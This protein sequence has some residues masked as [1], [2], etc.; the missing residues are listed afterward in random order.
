MRL[1]VSYGHSVR[2]WLN[3]VCAAM[4]VTGAFAVLAV[5]AAGPASVEV[6][7]GGP[8]TSADRMYDL[9][10]SA[11]GSASPGDTEGWATGP[12]ALPG[13]S[14]GITLTQYDTI[15]NLPGVQVA[16]PLTMVGYV[17]LTVQV[18]VEIPVVTASRAARPVTLTVRVSSDNG[19]SNVTWDDVTMAYPGPAVGRERSTMS[20]RLGWTFLLPLVAVD[21]VAEARLVGLDAAVTGGSYLPSGA[22]AASGPVPMLMAGSV[23]D[24][25]VADVSVDT[26]SG[27][28]IPAL[29]A[30]PAATA[31]QGLIG[32]AGESAAT[33]RTYW[34]ASPVTYQ[35][36]P[37][38]GAMPRPVATDLAAVWGGPYQWAGAPADAGVLDVTFR[39]LTAH[40]AG[41]GAALRAVGVFDPAKIAGASASPSPY[42]PT[43]LTG[44]DARSRQLLGGRPLTPD[45]APGGYN[46]PAA[47]LVIPLADI[48][49][50]TG[51]DPA[52]VGVIRVRVAG[53]AGGDSASLERIRAVAGE[54]VRATGL[55]V[56]AV[57]ASPGTRVIDLP[58]GLHGRP[59]LQ[60]S[61]SWYRNDTSTTVATGVDRHSIS[62]SELELAAGLLAVPSGILQMV[63]RRRRE[64]ET[65]RALGWGRRQAGR[66]LLAE[67]GLT[68]L[69]AGLTAVLT[70]GVVGTV[71]G[72]RPT[73]AWLLSVPAAIALVF[74][75][76]W[77][78]PRVIAPRPSRERP[79]ALVR[80]ILKV[81]VVALACA[82]LS[83]E[84]AVHWAFRG[85]VQSWAGRSASQQGTI[86][87]IAAVLVIVVMA[88]VMVADPDPAS[89]RERAAE[90]RIL[91]AIGWSARDVVWLRVRRAV[92]LGLAGGG[93]AGA[94]V[95]LGGHVAA[96]GAP[97]RL[98]GLAGLAT[99]AGVMVSLLAA[100]LSVA[101]GR[102]RRLAD[103]GGD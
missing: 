63:Q 30:V 64:L 49:A 62:L 4:A 25:E 13:Y 82:A 43:E 59:P 90:A 60:V 92:P 57:A 14:G 96:G 55:H 47:S 67:F 16:A 79:G 26:P 5:S 19:L 35:S 77:P 36:A 32:D 80:T 48:G 93:I 56:D 24:D 76:W 72:G 61:E 100:G 2:W 97:P 95:M 12:E 11:P 102:A 74:A 6:T 91:R 28:V 88:A 31:Y 98:I 86:V 8:G 52:P 46:S 3:V 85:A 58:A 23:A 70:V 69:A 68:A 87:D 7:G 29:R 44:A 103:A 15:R 71:L 65:L 39:S 54:I 78:L 27:A 22:A 83:L 45:G 18:P 101:W 89:R 73:W 37:N 21:P 9:V 81:I 42:V 17:P 1:P 20:V 66:Q 33:V 53:A 41:D 50:F 99:A 84:L 40:T 75:A 51:V 94:V 34:T 38:G 10:V